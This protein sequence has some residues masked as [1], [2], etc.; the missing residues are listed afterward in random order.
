M[1]EKQKEYILNHFDKYGLYN[2]HGEP[3]TR[4][5]MLALLNILE[6]NGET[7]DTLHACAFNGH[8]EFCGI[9]CLDG[10][11]NDSE[12]YNALLEHHIFLTDE[13]FIDWILEQIQEDMESGEDY[14]QHIYDM[15]NGDSDTQIYKTNDGYVIRFDY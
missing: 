6:V 2:D 7:L 15:T 5:E 4:A 8:I 3:I 14:A 13:G 1:N 9:Y 11:E 12:V 10:Y